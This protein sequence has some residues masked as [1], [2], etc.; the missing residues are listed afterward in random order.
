MG[1]SFYTT[2]IYS[3]IESTFYSTKSVRVRLA[4]FPWEIFLKRSSGQSPV[5][6]IPGGKSP[7]DKSTGGGGQNPVVKSVGAKVLF[8]SRTM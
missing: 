1:S 4:T 5:G 7:V 8:P 2:I 3:A 6:K